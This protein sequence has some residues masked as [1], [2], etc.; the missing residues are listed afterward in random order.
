MLTVK[1]NPG[2]GAKLNTPTYYTQVKQ[3]I[4]VLRPASSL[5]VICNHLNAQEF[6]TPTGLVWTRDRLANFIRTS[7]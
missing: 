7:I 5:R 2:F 6:K 4:A 1:A 3:I